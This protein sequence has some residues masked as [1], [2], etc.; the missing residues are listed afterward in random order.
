MPPLPDAPKVLRVALQFA[1]G[2]KTDV[3]TRFFLQYTG[4]APTDAQLNTY[5]GSINGEYSA[6]LAGQCGAQCTLSS[7][8]IIDL[9]SPTSAIGTDS[10]IVAGTRAGT[11]LSAN[12]CAI[13]SY[14]INRRYRGGHPRGYWPFGV[15]GDLGDP[16]HWNPSFVTEFT[17][18]LRAFFAAILGDAPAG[19]GMV[20]HVNV[21]YFAG[22][23]VVTSPITGRARNVPTLRGAPVVDQVLS[24]E[25]RE[26]VGTQ[27]RRIQ[28]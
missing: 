28:P 24:I 2:V 9:T 19:M 21:S 15:E 8:E 14:Q 20:S 23:T 12:D 25:G 13:G 22:F 27:R 17:G 5:A 6:D 16:Q 3:I 11:E 1:Y 18:A 7:I 10:T 4:S 26:L